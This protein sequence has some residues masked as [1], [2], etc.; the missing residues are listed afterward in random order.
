[1]DPLTKIIADVIADHTVSF[2]GAYLPIPEDAAGMLAERIVEAIHADR[3]I[4][5]RRGTRCPT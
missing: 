5:H 2:L 1:M 4:N 3:T